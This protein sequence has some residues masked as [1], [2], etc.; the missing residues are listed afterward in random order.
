MPMDRRKQQV[1]RAIVALYAMDGEPVGSGL[2]CQHLDMAVSSA[3]LRNEMAA[4]TKLGL[5][6]Q[7]HTS[8]GR[9][10][11]AKGYR[12]Y[13]DHLLSDGEA[14]PEAEA[15]RI[16]AA[17]RELDHAPER[18]AQ[19][20]ARALADD[21]CYAVAAT[22]PRSEE[23]RIAHFEVVQ[24]GRYSAAVLAVTGTGGVHTRVARVE[25]GLSRADAAKVAELLNRGLVFVAPADVTGSLLAGLAAALGE[26]GEALFPVIRAAAA[27]VRDAARPNA[28]LEGTQ[29]LLEWPDF[30]GYL[31]E[32][33][34]IFRDG[35]AAGRLIAPPT[36]R[37]SV[38]LGEDLPHPMPGLCIMSKR[39]LAG[40][41]LTG[42]IA[43]IGPA[44]MP[45]SKLM[46]RLEHYALRL[47]ENMSGKPQE[48]P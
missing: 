22:T 23:A 3:T 34:Q 28:T 40:G 6:E 8:A 43:I 42:S 5:L 19:G 35:E 30:S 48:E 26:Q 33:L 31:A 44:R 21:V 32:L 14:L 15:A 41:G 11:S 7:P 38:L 2:L 1:L 39:Y 4:L 29:Y 13:L 12:Y 36:N 47:G 20:T 37:T 25:T 18:L 24:V 27:L 16:D 45:F 17:L 9:V 10:P 46:P